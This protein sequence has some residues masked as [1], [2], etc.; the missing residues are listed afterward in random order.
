ML[1]IAS[2][3]QK[4]IQKNWHVCNYSTEN[5]DLWFSKDTHHISRT[6]KF[7][8]NSFTSK[9]AFYTSVMYPMVNRCRQ[10]K[11]LA[12]NR[13][14]KCSMLFWS[15]SSE[16]SNIPFPV[17]VLPIF[18]NLGKLQTNGMFIAPASRDNFVNYDETGR[19]VSIRTW[20]HLLLYRLNMSCW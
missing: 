5:S 13:L 10:R 20:V 4:K 2:A 18:E 16:C 6:A 12:D 19:L 7:G 11:Q 14:W 9:R 1:Y 3:A 8:Q 17:V 15:W